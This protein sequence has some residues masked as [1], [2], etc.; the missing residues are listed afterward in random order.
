M[1]PQRKQIIQAA[2]DALGTAGPDDWKVQPTSHAKELEARVPALAAIVRGSEPRTLAEQFEEDD[3]QALESQAKFKRTA[4]RANWAVL[5][6][7]VFSAALLVSALSIKD[8]KGSPNKRVLAVFGVCGVITGALGS[9]WVYQTREGR[10]L[11]DWKSARAAAEALRWQYFEKVTSLESLNAESAIPLPLLQFEYFRRYELDVQIKFYAKRAKEHKHDADYWMKLSSYSVALA[12]ISAGL[13]G[14][15]PAWVAVAALGSVATALGSFASTS[16]SVNQS[17]TNAEIYSKTKD[18][19]G[20]LQG[21]LDEVRAAAAAGERDPIKQFVAATHEQL[22]AEHR[23]WLKA[24]DSI[25][26][27]IDK[28]EE[29]LEKLKAQPQEHPERPQTPAG[30]TT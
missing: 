8:A 5:F 11:D 15:D 3:K 2:V 4:N 29:T 24:A 28:L 7:A 25:Q 10:L 27:A 14:L 30:S 6:T 26:P 19:L 21:K 13:A 16:D 17:R 1:S 18:A 9:M 22:A 23:Q 20:Q 12:S